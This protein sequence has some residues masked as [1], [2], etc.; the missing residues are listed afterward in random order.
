M[1]QENGVKFLPHGWN[2]AVGLAADLQ[3]SAVFANKD[4]VEYLTGSSY[5]DKIVVQPW[6]LDNEGMLS[7][8]EKPGLGIELDFE[9]VAKYCNGETFLMSNLDL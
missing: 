7:I 2:T 6:K 3:L 1:A 4:F 5:I 8:P 9:V